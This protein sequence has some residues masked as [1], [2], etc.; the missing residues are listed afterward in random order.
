MVTLENTQT[1]VTWLW[2]KE[3]LCLL[4]FTTVLQD[5]GVQGVVIKDLENSSILFMQ[6]KWSNPSRT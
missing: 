1:K 4:N 5:P 3:S 2:S 6:I